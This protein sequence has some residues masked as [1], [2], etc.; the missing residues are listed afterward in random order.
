MVQPVRPSSSPSSSSAP[1]LLLVFA[2]ALP[3]AAWPQAAKPDH[4]EAAAAAAAM[5]RA[6]RLASNPLRVILEA[7]KI[8]RRAGDGKPADSETTSIAAAPAA[9][10][11]VAAA[12]APPGKPADA[13]HAILTVGSTLTSAGSTAVAGLDD[14]SMARNI[15]PL[16]SAAAP[17][18]ALAASL[19]PPKLVSTVEPVMPARL[20]EEASRLTEVTAE[21]TIL[22]DGSVAEVALQTAVP[23]GLVRPI[24]AALEQWRFEPLSGTRV[25]RVQLVFRDER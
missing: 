13:P 24:T 12:A 18:A 25:H 8:R 6:Q 14:A 20:A 21:L 5:E 4:A 19:A 23:R 16:A 3:A 22:A 11:H 9:A 17:L 10:P 15:A 1:A 2:L 7:G